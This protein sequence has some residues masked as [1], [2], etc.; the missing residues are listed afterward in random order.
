MRRISFNRLGELPY[1]KSLY[2]SGG[3]LIGSLSRRLYSIAAASLTLI[4]TSSVLAQISGLGKGQLW[5]L[6]NGLQ[7]QGLSANFDPWDLT[8]FQNANYTA[9]NWLWDSSVGQQ[10][11]AP[12]AIPWARWVRPGAT[13]PSSAEMPPLGSEGPYM[14]KLIALSLGD[15]P[16]LNDSAVRDTYVNWFNSVA[17]SYPNQLLYMNNYGGQVTDGPLGDFIARAHPDMISFDTYPYRYAAPNDTTRVQPAGGSPTNWYG[18]LRKYRQH[19]LGNNIPM[20]MYRQTYHSTSEGVRD[21]SESELRLM[22]F[23]GLAFNSKY[24]TDFTYNSGASPMY[25]FAGGGGGTNTFYNYVKEANRQARNLG[26]ALIR[27]K[28]VADWAPDHTTSIMFV[29]GKHTTGPGTWAYNDFPGYIGFIPDP[30]SQQ[31]TDWTFAQN[32]PYLSGF[33]NVTN[34]GTKN[35]A[36]QGDMIVSWFKPLDEWFDGDDF[37]DERYIMVANGLADME[38]T[39]TDCRQTITLDFNNNVNTQ[40]I[41]VLDPNTG[42]I[43]DV[44]LPVVSTKRRYTLTLDGGSSVLLKFKDGAPFVGTLPPDAI[45]INSASGTFQTGGNWDIAASPGANNFLHFGTTSTGAGPTYTATLS[46]DL[47]VK[48]AFVHRDNVTWNLNGKT[49]TI[50]GFSGVDSLIVGMKAG[51]AGSLTVNNGTLVVAANPGY[52]SEIGKATG[53]TGVMTLGSGAVW[54]NS[55][56]LLIGKLGTGTL[57]VNA[58]ATAS[59][60][61]V[62]L[63]GGTTTAGGTGALNVV[64]GNTTIS[65]TLKLWTNSSA[66]QSGGS[67]APTTVQMT[68]GSFTRTAGTLAFANFNQTGGTSSLGSL[69]GTGSINLGG[70]ASTTQLTVSNLV[71]NSLNILANGRLI[72]SAGNGP[73]ASKVNTFSIAGGAAPTGTLN[74]NDNAIAINYTGSSPLAAIAAQIAAGYAAGS[75]TGPGINSASAASV[76]AD[77]SNPH[78]TAIGFAEASSIF[79]SF[80][81]MFLN[82]S[83]DN[84]TMLIRYVP[85]GDADLSGS[86]DTVDFNLLAASFSAT[87][88]RWVNGDF[89]FDGSVDTQDFNAL[90]ANFGYALPASA[91]L[92]SQLIPEPITLPFAFLILLAGSS[93]RARRS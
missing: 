12:G 58:G 1:N 62:C 16:N 7:L 44:G 54:N 34:L 6:R 43:S 91:T 89:N 81:A 24:I 57:N 21:P 10:G 18:D 50:S 73:T 51:E 48:G 71:E 25:G 68:G 60:T 79:S 72:V 52:Y 67:L 61:N 9:V 38:G 8:T 4:T 46:N 83:V 31:Y 77:S 53:A 74:L 23:A 41:Q 27:L 26:P 17:P 39:G 82:Q 78:K 56:D 29:R 11:A 86:V 20:G 92:Q 15:E 40:V 87:G 59:L 30:Q 93:R 13:P 85:S 69:S 64:G 28:P 45:W 5:F 66:N 47:S 33:T 55:T 70:G 49:L 42:S 22:T 65:G 36:L 3:R 75:W 2:E 76:A 90:A 84:T 14:S 32:D 35:D 19:A 63:G 80:P 88:Q 37:T